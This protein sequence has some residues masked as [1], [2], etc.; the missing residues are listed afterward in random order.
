MSIVFA[1]RAPLTMTPKHNKDSDRPAGESQLQFE[2]EV[3][4]KKACAKLGIR[5]R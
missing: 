1:S 2:L 3:K 5:M 4:R